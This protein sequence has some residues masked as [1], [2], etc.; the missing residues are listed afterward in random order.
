M[1][2]LLTFQIY[3]VCIVSSFYRNDLKEY[4]DEFTSVSAEF[5]KLTDIQVSLS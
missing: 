5:T 3:S 1:V 4:D 2:Y